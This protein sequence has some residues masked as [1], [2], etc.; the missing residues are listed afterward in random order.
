MTLLRLPHIAKAASE[1]WPNLSVKV[2]ST[3]AGSFEQEPCWDCDAMSNVNVAL[4]S[5]S[6]DQL[7]DLNRKL[8]TAINTLDG[9]TLGHDLITSHQVDNMSTVLIPAEAAVNK[10]D[11]LFGSK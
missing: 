5:N 6:K 11:H 3:L 9:S 4:S 2:N 10:Q 1:T 7:G 8:I